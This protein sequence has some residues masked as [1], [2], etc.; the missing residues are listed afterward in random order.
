MRPVEH[1]FEQRQRRIAVVAV[2]RLVVQVPP[3]YAAVVLERVQDI[4]DISL[5]NGIQSCGVGP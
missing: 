4:L 2:A 1:F 3:K 5:K